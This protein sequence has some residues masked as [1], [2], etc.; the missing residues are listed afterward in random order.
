MEGLD[1]FAPEQRASQQPLYVLAALIAAACLVL[2]F[3]Q[4]LFEVDTGYAPYVFLGAL[5]WLITFRDLRVG[6]ALTIIAIA[7]SPE[8]EIG[9]VPNLRMEDFIFPAVLLGWLARALHARDPLTATDLKTPLILLALVAV[10]SSLQN[11][12]YAR[13]PFWDSFF[14]LG[15]SCMYVL[16]FFVTMNALKKRKD[17]GIFM[18]LFWV[19]AVASALYAISRLWLYP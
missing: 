16:M 6:L 13:L 11:T 14:R 10:I 4:G 8:F 12:I 2:V 7:V 1:R 19:A 5:V 17:I 3:A 15:K 18:Q 9:G